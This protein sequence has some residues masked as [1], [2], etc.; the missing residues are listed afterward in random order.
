M[1]TV[2]N[3]SAEAM[4]SVTVALPD[5]T[6]RSTTAAGPLPAVGEVVELEDGTRVRVIGYRSIPRR[7]NGRELQQVVA[8]PQERP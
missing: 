6:E 2:R 5:G 4:Y 7:V 3:Q 8:V 1:V